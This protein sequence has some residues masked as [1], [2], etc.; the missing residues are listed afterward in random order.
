MHL[1]LLTRQR[2]P[3][4]DDLDRLHLK[5]TE[6]QRRQKCL[7]LRDTFLILEDAHFL[8]GRGV[9]E[10]VGDDDLRDGDVSPD[11]E[12]RASVAAERLVNTQDDRSFDCIRRREIIV[13][14]ALDSFKEDVRRACK[15]KGWLEREV[16]RNSCCVRIAH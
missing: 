6:V 16:R 8:L 11:S 13:E 4:K 15:L 12:R 5:P 9:L 10:E 2:L 14:P 1:P 7:I 3:P